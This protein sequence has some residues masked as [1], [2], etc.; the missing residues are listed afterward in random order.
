MNNDNNL[1]DK[2]KE[3]LNR[4]LEIYKKLTQSTLKPN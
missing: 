2:L 1:T 3:Q 4:V